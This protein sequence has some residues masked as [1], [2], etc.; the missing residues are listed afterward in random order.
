MDPTETIYALLS[1]IAS[2]DADYVREHSDALASWMERG[3]FVPEIELHR[4][5]GEI[6]AVIPRTPHSGDGHRG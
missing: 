6:V 3:G 1:A 2:G 5:S 4:D